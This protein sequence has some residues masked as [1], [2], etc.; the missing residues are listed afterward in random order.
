MNRKQRRRK[1]KRSHANPFRLMRGQFMEAVV[2]YAQD[3]L[4]QHMLRLVLLMQTGDEIKALIDRK[5]GEEND[6]HNRK[7]RNHANADHRRSERPRQG[8]T[9]AGRG[10]EHPALWTP[11]HRSHLFL[12]TAGR[13]VPP[14]PAGMGIRRRGM[15]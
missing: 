13:A 1:H 11:G 12:Q 8:P 14:L 15:V 10:L 5:R 3:R 7:G 6:H 4:V 2:R 9:N